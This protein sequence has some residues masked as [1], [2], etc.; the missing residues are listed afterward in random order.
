MRISMLLGFFLSPFFFPVV[1]AQDIPDDSAHLPKMIGRQK[2]GNSRVDA[3]KVSG[4]V[5]LDGFPPGQPRPAI[6]LIAK[7]FGRVVA[8]FQASPNGSYS[9]N[10][11]P[12][13]GST[14]AV[15][16]NQTE[17]ESQQII[18]T[19][20][21]IVYHNFSVNWLQIQK[22]Q[23]SSA[24]VDVTN[25]Y[26]RTSENRV[27][28]ESAIKKMNDG[29]IKEARQIL[30]AVVKADPNDF[31]AWTHLGHLNFLAKEYKTAE[32][33]YGRAIKQNPDY[34][35]ASLNLGR[36]YIAQSDFAPAINILLKAVD[37]QPASADANHY[38]G[39]VY[40]MS[41][42][43]SKAVVYLNEALRLAPIQKAEIHL[44]LAALYLGAGAKQRAVE[45]YKLF[46][47]KVPEYEKLKE[48]QKFISENSPA[49]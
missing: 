15:E 45:E 28:F 5:N 18:F 36:V 23:D 49:K 25:L 38:L 46:I 39:E 10:D 4:K 16:I 27:R 48:L 6:Y 14:I 2:G 42:L 19:P 26:N 35:P 30:G 20:S 22:R 44:R 8:R 40:L 9:L 17:V 34:F 21:N 1:S 41:K 13:Q 37:I 3:I 32:D 43:G 24:V 7:T 11:V 31:P 33:A 29:A 47:S 12:R